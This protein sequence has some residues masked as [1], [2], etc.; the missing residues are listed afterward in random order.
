M[1]SSCCLRYIIRK[2]GENI[3]YRFDICLFS[4]RRPEQL[5]F[6]IKK[7]FPGIRFL[8]D[9]FS[10][11]GRGYFFFFPIKAPYRLLHLLLPVHAHFYALLTQKTFY[12]FYGI[13]TIMNHGGDQRGIRL[14]PRQHLLQMQRPASP[15]GSDYGDVHIL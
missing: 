6:R 15:P 2:S 3:L 13:M 11:S 8:Q 10:H 1:K 4:G 5:L 7:W 9:P 14:S 12:L